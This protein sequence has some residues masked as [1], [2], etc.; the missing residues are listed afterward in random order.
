M[1]TFHYIYSL[2]V[3]IEVNT[4]LYILYFAHIP[5]GA[6]ADGEAELRGVERLA[7]GARPAHHARRVLV[8]LDSLSWS[9]WSLYVSLMSRYLCCYLCC[10]L[11][12][13]IWKILKFKA[14][15]WSFWVCFLDVSYF[16]LD[17]RFSSK[18]CQ[19]CVFTTLEMKLI[20]NVK[21]NICKTQEGFK[22]ACEILHCLASFQFFRPLIWWSVNS[23]SSGA[24]RCCRSQERFASD[25]AAGEVERRVFTESMNLWIQGMSMYQSGKPI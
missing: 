23:F 18:S 9:S 5:E 13:Y 14:K 19:N 24:G 16:F 3:T 25:A 11:V 8:S 2:E 1:Y 10:H 6:D 12:I 7:P 21:I 15:W 22:I 20:L 17:H 4:I